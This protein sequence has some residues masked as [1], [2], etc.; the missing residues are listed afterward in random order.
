MASNFVSSSVSIACLASAS[1]K[2]A[3]SV[4]RLN[5]SSALKP[6]DARAMSAPMLLLSVVVVGGVFRL[7]LELRQLAITEHYVVTHTQRHRLIQTAAQVGVQIA[8]LDY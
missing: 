1:A 6:S 3:C 7:V 8:S 4:S 2:L 5:L